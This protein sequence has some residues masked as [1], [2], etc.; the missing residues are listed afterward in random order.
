[1][2]LVICVN[3]L[4]SC[5]LWGLNILGILFNGCCVGVVMVLIFGLLINICSRWLFISFVVFV[6]S[7]WFIFVFL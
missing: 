4:F 5:G 1:M 7:I 3:V 2:G 6:I